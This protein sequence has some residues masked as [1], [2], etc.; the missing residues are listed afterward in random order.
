MLSMLYSFFPLNSFW[1]ISASSLQPA[2]CEPLAASCSLL[3]F[4][5][6]IRVLVLAAERQ[7]HQI[8]AVDAHPVD[9]PL[10]RAVR[11]EGDPFAVRRPRRLLVRSFARDDAALLGRHVGDADLEAPGEAR[12][13]GHPLP[14][15]RPGGVV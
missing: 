10:A 5:R 14:V 15:G 4:L 9:L 3:R 12:G 1:M 8:R 7:L 13:V 6:P 2:L 11:L